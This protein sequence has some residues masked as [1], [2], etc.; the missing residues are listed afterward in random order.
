MM[1]EDC[2]NLAGEIGQE[3]QHRM[4]SR[5]LQRAAWKLPGSISG[6]S[7]TGFS[8]LGA[9]VAEGSV[10][11]L[12]GLVDQIVPFHIEVRWWGEGQVAT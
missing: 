5:K 7:L 4:V 9:Q 12:M 8:I 1:F 11:D 6:R 2:R 3:F 10:E